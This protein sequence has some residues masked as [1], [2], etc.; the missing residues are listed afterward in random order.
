MRVRARLT[1]QEMPAPSAS[2]FA[3]IA[4]NACA[5]A[6]SLIHVRRIIRAI[7]ARAVAQHG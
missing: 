3:G 1:M 7:K 4:E 2:T 6:F 5:A